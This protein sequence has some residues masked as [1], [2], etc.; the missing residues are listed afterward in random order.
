MLY[1]IIRRFFVGI[2]ICIVT[3]YLGFAGLTGTLILTTTPAFSQ[4]T[5]QVPGAG[6]VVVQTLN[7]GVLSEKGYAGM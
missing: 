3:A 4:S 1:N 6:Q 7:F 5:G 2:S